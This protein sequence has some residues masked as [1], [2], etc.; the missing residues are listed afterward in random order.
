MKKRSDG[1]TLIEMLVIL[2]ILSIVTA[3]S[4]PTFRDAILRNQL[5]SSANSFYSLLQFARF[6][7]AQSGEVV[8]VGALDNSDWSNGAVAWIDTDADNLF[9]GT[10]DSE[11]RR[12]PN[13][14]GLRL[15][16]SSKT[17]YVSFNGK[18]YATSELDIGFC[19]RSG[20]VN[21][22]KLKMLMSGI[23]LVSDKEDCL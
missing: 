6:K 13:A 1:F 9:D 15:I 11:L 14:H 18:G 21:G 2:S 8:Y 7:A 16:E 19:D 3:F 12:A 10:K 5:K 22:K 20:H 23:A 17:A 4:V